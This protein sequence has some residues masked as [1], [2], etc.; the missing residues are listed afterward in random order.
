MG[1]AC[2]VDGDKTAFQAA[3]GA[4][5]DAFD[6]HGVEY[7][8]ADDDAVE[9]VGQG[10]E[11]ADFASVFGGVRGDVFALALGEIG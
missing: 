4:L 1:K 2:A 3:V 9:T 5:D 8:V 7:F 10:A 6:G 11:M